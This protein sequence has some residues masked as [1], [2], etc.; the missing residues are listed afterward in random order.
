V[1]LGGN[2]AFNRNKVLSLGD[3]AVKFV[4][5]GSSFT[6]RLTNA[7]V[8]QPLGVIRGTDFAR[9]RYGETANTVGTVDVN[10]VCR[11]ANA[12]DG[13]L[14][15]GANGFPIVDPTLRA[16]G[17][18]QPNY[19]A[20]LRSNIG[21]RR[22]SLG[23]F[24][25]IRRGGTLQNMTKASMYGQGTHGDTQIRGS[26]VTFG[27]DFRIAGIGPSSYPVVGPGVDATT[28]AGR[29]VAIGEPW[30]TGT[31]GIGGAAS[32]FQ[33]GAGFVRLRE[34]SL[35]LNLD[36]AWVQRRTGFRSLDFRVSGRNLG[37][38]TK[39]TGYDPE[40]SLS[41]GAVITQGFDWFNPPT[42]RS[43]VLSVG[44]NR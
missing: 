19:T 21:F 34:V 26:N 15:L 13:A 11:A 2:Y 41:G 25:D 28:G 10:S 9:C 38:W 22:L 16:L 4:T 8:G 40:T 23:A 32:Q 35:G 17:N 36:Q 44:L 18:P 31:G 39:Y 43:V 5:V 7:E 1:E 33:E 6:G 42:S 37:L 30:Y 14:Y 3:T 27:R 20:G 29:P 12:P 24:V